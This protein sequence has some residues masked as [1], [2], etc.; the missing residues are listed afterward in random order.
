MKRV[1]VSGL[2]EH[3]CKHNIISKAQHEFLKHLSTCTNLLESFNDWTLSLQN[4]NAVTVAYVDFTEAF[5]TVTRYCT[6]CARMV[7]MGV[8]SHG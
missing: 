8:S 1:I 6:V 4:H 7:L 2:T 3:F 5:D